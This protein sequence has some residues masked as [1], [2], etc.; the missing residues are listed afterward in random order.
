MATKYK[1]ARQL[2]R[3]IREAIARV[4]FQRDQISSRSSRTK[5]NFAISELMALLM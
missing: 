2:E 4:Q 3:R 1:T 5:Y